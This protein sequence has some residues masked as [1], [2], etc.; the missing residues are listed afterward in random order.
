MDFSFPLTISP[1][2]GLLLLAI[3]LAFL[4]GS[5]RAQMGND[6]PTG[7]SGAYNGNVNTAGSYDPYTGNATRSVTDITVAGAVGAYPLAF[8]RT[9]N[10]R[11]TVGAGTWEMGTA[12]SWRHNY[13]WSI[14]P[15]YLDS[16]NAG[17]LPVTYT[18]DYPDGRRVSFSAMAGDSAF[19]GGLGI[20][21]RFQQMQSEGDPNVY[22]LL[23]DG[24]KIW[25]EVSID[26][27]QLWDGGP[28]RS[29][30]SYSFMGI[31][32]PYGQTTTV[33][34]PA[35]GS[36]TITEP[37]GRWL[38][39]FYITTPWM[40]DTVLVN[41]QASDGR[42]VVY[43]YGPY[44]PAGATTY[45]YLGNVQYLDTNGA[46]YAQAI[47][48]YQPSNTDANG[49][50]LIYWAIDPMYT[51]PMWAIS[52]FFVPGSAGGVY[53]QLQSENYLDPFTGTPGQA[54]SSLSQN[55]NTRTETRGDGPSRTFNYNGGKLVNYTDFRG[56]T[57]YIP[58][59]ATDS[60]PG[61]PTREITSRLL[62]AIVSSGLSAR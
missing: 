1:R 43:N 59:M 20:S 2:L 26:R 52:Y 49:R 55:G 51:G 60:S 7:I 17:I 57:S 27:E 53:G 56:H 18:V 58:T 47:Y 3:S 34:Y 46:S 28:T 10:S 62:H 33:S 29:S 61:L 15:T 16:Y 21:D 35:D 50:P 42:S 54:V 40:G 39:L 14:K 37:A 19:R 25:F 24:G 12:G 41:V 36:M 30:F 5:L 22:L 48:A 44:Q 11:Y 8:T 31:I 23:P 4:P 32:D 9:M 6:N 38:K 13:Q 45:S